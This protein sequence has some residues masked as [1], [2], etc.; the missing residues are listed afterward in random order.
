[1]KQDISGIYKQDFILYIWYQ[2]NK[3]LLSLI[4]LTHGHFLNYCLST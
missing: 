1:M 3:R 2:R 4:F